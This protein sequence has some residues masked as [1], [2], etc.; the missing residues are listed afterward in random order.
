MFPLSFVDLKPAGVLVG[1]CMQQEDW[2][3]LETTDP[4]SMKRGDHVLKEGDAT[5]AVRIEKKNSN[6]AD[7]TSHRATFSLFNLDLSLL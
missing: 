2:K 5:Q 1:G 4:M 3:E 6:R 7:K